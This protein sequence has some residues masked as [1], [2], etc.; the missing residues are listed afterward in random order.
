MDNFLQQGITAAKSGNKAQAYQLLTRATQENSTAEQ[1]WLWLATVVPSNEERLFCLDSALRINPENAPAKNKAAEYRQKG[2]FPAVPVPPDDA[3]LPTPPVAQTAV[4]KPVPYPTSP[5]S[6]SAGVIAQAPQVS[7]GGR[8]DLSGLFRFAA[9]ELAK[10]QSSKNVVQKLIA[11]GVS[12]ATAEQVV[13]ETKKAFAERH[14]KR[15]IR[16]L[17]WTIGGIVVTCGTFA[18]ADK[19]GGGYVLFWG[20]IAYGLIDF[21]AGL[22]GWLS[23]R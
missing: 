8:Q 22:I 6:P 19:L 5:A 3:P 17:L 4:P 7:T 11:Q 1:A 21:V 13:I 14:R 12:P 16:G 18:F 9:Q 20:A 15:M 2:V 23:N 10:K